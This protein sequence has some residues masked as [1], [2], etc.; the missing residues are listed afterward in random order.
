MMIQSFQELAQRAQS[1]SVKTRIALVCAQDRH[2]LEA[3]TTARRDGIAEGILI[4]DEREIRDILAQL[5][6]N[7]ANYEIIPCPDKAQSIHI[8]AELVRQ[9]KAGVIMKGK[10]ETGDIMRGI[11]DKENGLRTE[12]TLSVTGIYDMKTYPKIFGVSDVA[13]STYPDLGKKKSILT[14]AVN[15]FHA[16]GHENPKVAVLAAVEKVN[17]KMNETVEADQ[18]KQMNLSGEIKGCIVEGP[19]SFDLATDPEAAAIKGY[20]GA[21][22]GDADLLIAPDLICGNVLVKCLTGLAGA[23]TAGLVLGAK[24]PMVL[25]SRAATA[26]DKYYSIAMAA[27]TAPYFQT[28]YQGG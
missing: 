18:L 2:G 20:Q 14:N 3:I 19:I 17:P 4:G 13:I 24:V 15:L 8:A 7:A 22:A 23:T 5:G 21:V 16:L 27:C 9:G 25:V 28:L 10:M 6:E 11:L 26:D 12:N 1:M